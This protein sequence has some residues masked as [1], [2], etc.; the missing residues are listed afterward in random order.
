MKVF[1]KSDE[2]VLDYDIVMT[3]WLSDGDVVSSAD[4]TVPDGIDYLGHAILDDKVKVWIGGGTVDEEYAFKV[5]VTT[6]GG[7]TKEVNFIMV[8][9]EV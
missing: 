4:I 8:V 2:D 3:Y 9:T 7:R 1:K 6:Y 5:L